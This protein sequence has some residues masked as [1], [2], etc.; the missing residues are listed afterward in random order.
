MQSLK[1]KL[2]N[3]SFKVPS[4]Q[5]WVIIAGAAALIYFLNNLNLTALP[6]P[7]WEKQV[8][9]VAIVA[10]TGFLTVVEQQE[11]GNPTPTPNPTPSNLNTRYYCIQ[12]E[13]FIADYDA[14]KLNYPNDQVFPLSGWTTPT[15]TV[16]S[17]LPPVKNPPAA[18]IDLRPLYFGGGATIYG[19]GKIGNCT[20]QTGREDTALVAIKTGYYGSAKPLPT[21]GFSAA[22]LYA[23]ERLAE[24][25]FPDDAGA[26]PQEVG[27][28]LN[29]VGI[30]FD[31][32]MPTSQTEC[33]T[34]PTQA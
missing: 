27:N 8:L 10:V 25:S 20:A 18:V 24:N 11:G 26:T 30:C 31:S 16:S 29:Y 12:H 6:I 23:E 7:D 13:D 22:F 9:S 33:A 4:V 19:Q 17:P 15:K 1:T 21:N 32:D 5:G 2:S 14:H 28:M 34:A 3:L